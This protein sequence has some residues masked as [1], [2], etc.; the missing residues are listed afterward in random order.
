MRRILKTSVCEIFKI[1]IGP[2]S[3]HTVGPT[4]AAAEFASELVSQGFIDAVRRMQVDLYGSLALT[5]K[6]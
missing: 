2:F 6:G 3:S 4:S 5:G 1:G